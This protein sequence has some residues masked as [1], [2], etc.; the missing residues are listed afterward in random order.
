MDEK[1]C[2]VIAHKEPGIIRD[3]CRRTIGQSGVDRQSGIKTKRRQAL[4]ILNPVTEVSSIA[5]R[6]LSPLI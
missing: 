5:S 3:S 4:I 2:P 6:F 1:F